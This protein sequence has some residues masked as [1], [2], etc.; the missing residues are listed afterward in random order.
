MK[1]HKSGERG[2]KVFASLHCQYNTVTCAEGLYTA[3]APRAININPAPRPQQHQGE[4]SIPI[5]LMF[6]VLQIMLPYIP[7]ERMLGEIVELE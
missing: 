6:Q 1:E 3:E 7:R 4:V 5:K 2:L